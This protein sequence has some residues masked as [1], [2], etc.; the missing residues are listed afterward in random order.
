MKQNSARR[1]T[2]IAGNTSSSVGETCPA[3][4]DPHSRCLGS[5]SVYDVCCY[6]Y[7]ILL[8]FSDQDIHEDL[9]TNSVCSS[10]ICPIGK[11]Q[12]FTSWVLPM[13]GRWLVPAVQMMLAVHQLPVCFVLQQIQVYLVSLFQETVCIRS[14]SWWVLWTVMVMDQSPD[15]SLDGISQQHRSARATTC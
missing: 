15:V 12:M 2:Q 13:I 3:T 1:K 6:I 4:L 10:A 8:V 7:H 14:L 11:K 5:P 9:T